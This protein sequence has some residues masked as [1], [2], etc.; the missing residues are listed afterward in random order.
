MIFSIDISKIYDCFTGTTDAIAKNQTPRIACND[1]DIFNPYNVLMH[2][3]SLCGDVGPEDRVYCHLI[4][5]QQIQ[6]NVLK[7]SSQIINPRKP[8]GINMIGK[9]TKTLAQMAGIRHWEKV[10]NHDTR[11]GAI[12]A[13]TNN[14]S[15]NPKDVQLAAR[16]R[17]IQ[18]QQAYQRSTSTSDVARQ[19][20]LVP[21]SVAVRAP[22]HGPT[23]M[24][25]MTYAI[26]HQEGYSN[27]SFVVPDA[28]R[29]LKPTSNAMWNPYGRNADGKRGKWIVPC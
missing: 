25:G 27:R 15:V 24:P 23:M 16:H 21:P 19:V 5:S 22:F 6:A 11:Q 20:A 9:L 13:L 18:S 10:T 7:G 3:K 8:M 1:N 28:H 26:D 2:Y 29:P 14:P 12:D 4:G 17:S